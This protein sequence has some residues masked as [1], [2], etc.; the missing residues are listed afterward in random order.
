MPFQRGAVGE[1]GVSEAI[2]QVATTDDEIQRRV[3]RLLG[4]LL[5]DMEYLLE[6]GT[7]Q[8]RISLAR[9]VV[10]TMMKSLVV[11]ETAET[12][13]RD[14]YERMMGELRGDRP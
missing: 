11:T 5:D 2:A 6:Y 3:R 14:A 10:P 7:P 1:Q 13:M 8:E 12:D 9:A 4:R